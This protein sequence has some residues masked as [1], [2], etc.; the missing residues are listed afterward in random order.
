MISS[1]FQST[2]PVRGATRT[3]LRAKVGKPVSIHAPRA[4]S[5]HS[6]L[7]TDTRF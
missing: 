6:H 2:P 7:K 1:K 3:G 4:G 5:D